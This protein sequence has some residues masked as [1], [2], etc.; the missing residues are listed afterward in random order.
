MIS[1]QVQRRAA[2]SIKSGEHI[3]KNGFDKDF[4]Q[5][6][7]QQYLRG[8][9]FDLRNDLLVLATASGSSDL[10][11]GVSTLL[12]WARKQDPH[13]LPERL[14]KKGFATDLVRSLF[15][16][17]S[18]PEDLR[19][20]SCVGPEDTVRVL[21]SVRVLFFDFESDPSEQLQS[22]IQICTEILRSGSVDEAQDLWWRLCSIASQ[23]RPQAGFLDLPH[24]LG[25][26]RNSFPLKEYPAY[27]AD[28]KKL[29]SDTQRTL[30]SIRANIG[31]HVEFDRQ[32]EENNLERAI[33]QNRVCAVVGP[34]GCGKSVIV[35][36]WAEQKSSLHTLVFWSANKLKTG[37][38]S[39][40]AVGTLRFNY[41]LDEV[42]PAASRELAYF[43]IDGLDHLSEE[44]EF[45][46]LAEVSRWLRLEETNSPWRLVLTCQREEWGRVQLALIRLGGLLSRPS[47]LNIDHPAIEQLDAVWD[48]FPSL[49]RLSSEKRLADML[50]K[51]K[52]LDLF[53]TN[54]AAKR[55]PDTQ[56]W[57]GESDL[58]EWF[59]SAEVNNGANGPA[60]SFLLQR[61]GE[62]QADT[63]QY[64]TGTCEFTS[65][66]LIIFE[67]LKKDRI[68][69]IEDEKIAF[70][71][72]LFGDWSRQRVLLSRSHQ[73]SEF[74]PKKLLSPPWCRAVRLFGLHLLELKKDQRQWLDILSQLAENN[75]ELG[76]NLLLET[77]IFASNPD[78]ILE[79][80]W[81]TLVEDKGRLLWR[82]LGQFL[83]VA[84]SPDLTMLAATAN[85]TPE[86]RLRFAAECRVPILQLWPA[87]LTFLSDHKNEVIRLAPAGVV[88]I[89]D[90]WLRSTLPGSEARTVAADLA[91]AGAEEWLAFSLSSW[92]VRG[93]IQRVARAILSGCHCRLC[94]ITRARP[95]FYFD[96]LRQKTARRTYC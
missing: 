35:K 2:V 73:L 45:A 59:W 47:L 34:S 58:I 50:L 77:I 66:D 90:M 54:I 79:N 69:A 56:E 28:W 89:C 44:G 13:D 88:R 87:V 38:F 80:L 15:N 26:L 76:Q 10:K 67:T 1:S 19:N 92:T 32:L 27:E 70:D 4:V 42:I 51:P 17:F 61:L 22:D 95:R 74:L 40:T 81:E 7:W 49:Q 3:T 68:C 57:V 8:S 65:D 96:C 9:P 60:R 30:N 93:G 37:Q 64:E 16:S 5:L 11:R 33:E 21:R 78:A 84:T 91:L 94:R 14:R 36:K 62:N 31:G 85:K 24:L 20:A 25:F 82:F 23:D 86:I 83:Q 48:A 52:I 71:H 43:V 6:A 46:N 63:M 18:C 53:A 55:V 29:S 12:K 41:E 72:D 75:S 39:T